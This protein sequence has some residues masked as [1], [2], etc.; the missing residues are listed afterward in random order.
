MVCLFD[1]AGSSPTQ[2]IRD[3]DGD[4]IRYNDHQ[5]SIILLLGRSYCDLLCTS[6]KEWKLQQLLF[7]FDVFWFWDSEGPG[8]RKNIYLVQFSSIFEGSNAGYVHHPQPRLW[9]LARLT[10]TDPNPMMAGCPC[11]GLSNAIGLAVHASSRAR[12]PGM[13]TKLMEG[14]MFKS[15]KTLHATYYTYIHVYIHIYI[16]IYTQYTLHTV[17]YTLHTIHYILLTIHYLLSSIYYILYIEYYKLYTIY[18]I[19]YTEY[20]VSFIMIYIYMNY[21]IC[22]KLY[23]IFH[24]P[25]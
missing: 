22:S 18:H 8:W 20:H 21:T 5:W 24:I 15:K 1:P 6:R 4:T 10:A 14:N 12:I 13:T 17:H 9:C 7:S 2:L 25:E 19:L 11:E 16:Y 23:T 3:Q